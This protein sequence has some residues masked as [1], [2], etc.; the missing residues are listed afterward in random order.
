[1]KLDSWIILQHAETGKFHP[2]FFRDKRIG[3]TTSPLTEPGLVQLVSDFHHTDG[4]DHVDD[5][6]KEMRHAARFCMPV[7]HKNICDEPIEWDGEIG[8]KIVLRDW[9]AWG[10]ICDSLHAKAH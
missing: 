8:I 6:I 9:R 5:A 10:S 3:I 7:S 1:M 4:F 2:A